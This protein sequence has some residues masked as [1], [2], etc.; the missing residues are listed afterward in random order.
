M[1]NFLSFD[2]SPISY[3]PHLLASLVDDLLQKV[4]ELLDNG[5]GLTARQA[6]AVHWCSRVVLR[7]TINSLIMSDHMMMHVNQA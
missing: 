6:H 3:V 5:D 1:S 4:G 2:L 7:P